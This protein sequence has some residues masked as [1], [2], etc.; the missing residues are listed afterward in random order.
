MKSTESTLAWIERLAWGSFF[1][2]ALMVLLGVMHLL[3]ISPVHLRPFRTNALKQLTGYTLLVL[4]LINVLFGLWRA[5]SSDTERFHHRMLIHQILG[6]I[7][8]VGLFLHASTVPSG[9]LQLVWGLGAALAM[10]GGLRHQKRWPL[11]P[12]LRRNMMGIHITTSCLVLVGGTLHLYF[13]YT[14]AS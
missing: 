4:I 14:Y 3:G 12:T 8:T 2:G 11:S 5:P 7:T 10:S 6:L 13:V 1:V 9:Y